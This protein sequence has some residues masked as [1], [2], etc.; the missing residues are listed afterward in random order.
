MTDEELNH[1]L[2][3][4]RLSISDDQKE[5]LKKDIESIISFFDQIKEVNTDEVVESGLRLG[6]LKIREDIPSPSNIDLVKYG[7][8]SIDSFYTVPKVIEGVEE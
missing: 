3:L 8:Q 7:P 1:L 4:S 2:T 6:P 5:K